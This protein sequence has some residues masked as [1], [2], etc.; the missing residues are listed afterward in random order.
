MSVVEIQLAKENFKFS[1]GHFTIFSATDREDLH[2]HNFTVAVSLTCEVVSNGMTFD[3]G[4]AK[5]AVEAI[6]RSL[7]EK[8]L[9]P[10]NSEFLTITDAGNRLDLV[11]NDEPFSFLKRDAMVL[12]VANVTVE[13]LAQWFLDQLMQGFAS[14]PANRIIKVEVAVNSGPGQGARVNRCGL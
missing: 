11:F 14:D 9:L 13:E 8:F 2:G 5:R 4:L 12:P 10:G 1:A 7:N 6:C 3:Y